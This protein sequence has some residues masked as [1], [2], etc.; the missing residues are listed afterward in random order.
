MRLNAAPLSCCGEERAD[1]SKTEHSVKK[2]LD[3]KKNLSN[4][5]KIEDF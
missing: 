5:L 3:E 4:L 2:K 1:L